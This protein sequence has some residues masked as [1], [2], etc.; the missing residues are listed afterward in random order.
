MRVEVY[1]N[2]H[3]KCL[4]VRALEGPDKGRVVLHAPSVVLSNV[5]FAVSQAGRERVLRE[6]RKNVHAFV[7]GR[8][9]YHGEPLTPVTFRRLATYNPYKY[10]SFVD[11]KTEAPLSHAND[12]VI[13]GREVWYA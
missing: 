12:V 3:K 4:S 9:L 11:K 5:T 8:L 13:N 7:R 2:L 6:K 10:N 1:Y